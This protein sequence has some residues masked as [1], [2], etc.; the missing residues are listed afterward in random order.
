MARCSSVTASRSG[1]HTPRVLPPTVI[2]IS[3]VALRRHIALIRAEFSKL[4]IFSVFHEVYSGRRLNKMVDLNR[5]FDAKFN[6]FS[7]KFELFAI[8]RLI[9]D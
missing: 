6:N 2:M 7:L 9:L 4:W 1:R 5:F 3:G 8:E